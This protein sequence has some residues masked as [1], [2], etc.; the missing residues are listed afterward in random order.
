MG[1]NCS[2]IIKI[3]DNKIIQPV[4]IELMG[5]SLEEWFKKNPNEL[6]YFY[7][8]F[9]GKSSEKTYFNPK[10][11]LYELLLDKGEEFYISENST[12][13]KNKFQFFND[14]RQSNL[15][16]KKLNTIFNYIEPDSNNINVF[17]LEL[18]NIILLCSMEVEIHWRR[19]L[20][21]NGY[22]KKRYSTKDYVKLQEFIDFNFEFELTN[23][24][25]FPEITPFKNW[26]FENPTQSLSWFDAYNKI[27]HNRSKYLQT[28]TFMEAINSI[29]ALLT[30]MYIRYNNDLMLHKKLEFDYLKIKKGTRISKHGFYGGSFSPEIKYLKYFNIK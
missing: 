26:D 8:S 19:L 30:L 9:E 12:I 5:L 24:S 16:L 29:C 10:W 28:A 25:N 7:H 15:L 22:Q 3:S 11:T 13:E 1:K 6:T 2:P 18:R 23:F 14:L 27:K 17:S 20:L 21:I 4:E